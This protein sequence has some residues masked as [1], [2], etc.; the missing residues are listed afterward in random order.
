[1]KRLFHFFAAAAVLVMGVACQKEARTEGLK[2]GESLV[3]FKVEVPGDADTKAIGDGSNVDMLY[4]EV[5]NA[6]M[7]KKLAKGSKERSSAKV[8]DLELTLVQDQTYIFL[9]WAQV[10]P[11]ENEPAIY[12]VNDLTAVTVDYNAAVGNDEDRA[13]FFAADTLAI[14]KNTLT[15]DIY[16]KRPFAQLNFG[17][18]TFVSPDMLEPVT[19]NSSLIKVTNASTKFDVHN[20]VGSADAADAAQVEFT[21]AGCPTEPAKLTVGTDEYEYLSMNYFFVGGKSDDVKIEAMFTTSVGNVEHSII[22]VPVAQNYRTNII[23]DLLFNKADFR[24]IVDERFAGD[25]NGGVSGGFTEVPN[26]DFK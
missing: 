10:D 3:S 26:P 20:G 13:A 2:K 9:F 12:T 5:Y 8:F 24:I 21:A 15:H 19:V 7:S 14:N 23:G 17:T 1:M 6:D 22:S 16:L 18:T 11:E 4:Y 25:H